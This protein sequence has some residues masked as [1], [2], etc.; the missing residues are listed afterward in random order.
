MTCSQ[1]LFIPSTTCLLLQ[2]CTR[3][4]LHVIRQETIHVTSPNGNLLDLIQAERY[5][6]KTRRK[7]IIYTPENDSTLISRVK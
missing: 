7:V 6:P 1:L 3:K 4:L 5:E 2:T